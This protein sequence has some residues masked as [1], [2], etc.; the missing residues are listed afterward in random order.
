M[1][2]LSDKKTE[3][4]VIIELFRDRFKNFPGG[5]LTVSESPDFILSIGPEKK[6]GL[7]LTRLHQQIK[8]TDPFSYENIVACLQQKEE[9]L[10]LYRRKRLQEYW[11]ILF[12]RDPAY[13]PRYNLYNKLI[14]WEFETD[15]NRVFFFNLLNS[16]VFELKKTG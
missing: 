7:E 13:S 4:L 10:E 16:D 8:G 9:K 12:V 3:E 2:T 15:F 6:L 14:V 11:L 5:V 1:K